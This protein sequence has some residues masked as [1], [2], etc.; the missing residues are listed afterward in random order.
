MAHAKIPQRFRMQGKKKKS[1]VKAQYLVI[2]I[3][4]TQQRVLVAAMYHWCQFFIHA[5]SWSPVRPKLFSF[6]FVEKSASILLLSFFRDTRLLLSEFR[7][8]DLFSDGLAFWD[9]LLSEDKGGLREVPDLSAN[10]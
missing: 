9:A 1:Y 6:L 2:M 5:V 3:D 7:C 10:R 8:I 4:N